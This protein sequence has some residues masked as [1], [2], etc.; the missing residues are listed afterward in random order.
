MVNRTEQIPLDVDLVFDTVL[1]VTVDA[2]VNDRDGGR[3]GHAGV[4][5]RHGSDLAGDLA[6]RQPDRTVAKGIPGA[7]RLPAI[8]LP[9]R[10]A[11]DEAAHCLF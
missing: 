6:E 1:P 8:H 9:A 4:A 11:E 7:A 10:W 2:V 5:G 3:G